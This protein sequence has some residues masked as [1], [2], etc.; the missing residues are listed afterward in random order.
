MTE[1]QQYADKMMTMILLRGA[2]IPLGVKVDTRIYRLKNPFGPVSPESL[3]G[4]G[5]KRTRSNVF[6]A[7]KALRGCQFSWGFIAER[8]HRG[9]KRQGRDGIV[10]QD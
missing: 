8:K 7:H 4:R 9:S 5:D 6:K 10:Q 3:V 1:Q 2:S